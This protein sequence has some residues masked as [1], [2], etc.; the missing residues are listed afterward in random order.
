M[1]W[2]RGIIVELIGLFV[3]DAAFAA[4]ILAIVA[5]AGIASRYVHPPAHLLGFAM[6][7][8][9]TGILIGSAILKAR[10]TK[11]AARRDY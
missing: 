10:R 11:R 7:T 2:L 1:S 4:C 3:D 6:F 9:L 5:A 8:A